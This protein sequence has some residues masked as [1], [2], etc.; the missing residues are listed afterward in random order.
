MNKE[1][2]PI[3]NLREDIETEAKLAAGKDG[4]GALPSDFWATY[5]AFAN[6]D[7]GIILLGVSE[8]ENGV[9]EVIGVEEPGRVLQSL[10]TLLNNPQS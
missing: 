1:C 7:G 9:F 6:T 8:K 2:F 4:K 3:D 5:S 10:W